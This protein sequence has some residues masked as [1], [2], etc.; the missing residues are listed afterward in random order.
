MSKNIIFCADGTW[1]TPTETDAAIIAPTNV[2]K[3][4]ALLI[5][6]GSTQIATYD[7]GIGTSD[8]TLIKL[9]EGVT[10]AGLAAKIIDGY[11]F[12]L[13]Q[14]Q[15]GDRVFLFGFS[16]GAY[17]VR[18]LGAM[19]AQCGLIPTIAANPTLRKNSVF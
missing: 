11:H 10:G 1:D 4:Y 14:W 17:T 19:I 12:I 3:L 7:P 5:N 9:F 6:D 16:R 13:N 15:A 8:N 18:C 2:S